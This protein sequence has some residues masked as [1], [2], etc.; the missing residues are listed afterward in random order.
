LGEIFERKRKKTQYIRI[1]FNDKT[2][3]ENEQAKLAMPSQNA[4]FTQSLMLYSV[5]QY[6]ITTTFNKYVL[7]TV[8][9][10]GKKIS[11]TY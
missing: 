5:I 7:H 11:Y 3:R 4:C 6:T 1:H 2:T 9:N 10:C 8:L